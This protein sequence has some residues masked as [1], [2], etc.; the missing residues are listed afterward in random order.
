MCLVLQ[1]RIQRD[2]D[3]ADAVSAPKLWHLKNKEQNKKLC[4]NL[5]W[6]G[7]VLSAVSS[8]VKVWNAKTFCP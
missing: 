8:N 7:S 5:K 1:R 4:S 6:L 2:F 3:T